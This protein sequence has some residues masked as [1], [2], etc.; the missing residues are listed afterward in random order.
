VRPS[1]AAIDRWIRRADSILVGHTHFD[2]ALDVPAIA[3]RTGARVYG[4][5]S[6]TTLMGLYGLEA[7]AVTA[8]PYRVYETGPFRITFVP[9]VHSTLMLGKRVPMAGEITCDH[10]DGLIPQAYRCSQTWGIHIAVVGM[11]IYHQG[12]ADMVDDA[13]RHTDV[14]LFLCGIAGREFSDRYVDRVMRKLSPRVVVPMHFDDFLRPLEAPLG[15]T[16]GVDLTGFA[17]EVRRVSPGIAVRT[18]HPGRVVA[19]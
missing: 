12:S 16:P 10:L 15:F 8:E 11:S 2:H 6:M 14:D 9:S 18:L 3:R 1:E 13:V 5:T 7:Q 4:S 19:V 17:E